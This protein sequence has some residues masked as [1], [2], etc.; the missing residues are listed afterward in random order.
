MGICPYQVCLVLLTYVL[1]HTNGEML[2]G[3]IRGEDEP[4]IASWRVLEGVTEPFDSFRPIDLPVWKQMKN[5]ADLKAANM[6]IQNALHEYGQLLR[7]W[8]FGDMPHEEGL[9]NNMN[10]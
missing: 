9:V 7:H 1:L 2:S 6:M 3:R 10:Y 8:H 4:Q 5:S